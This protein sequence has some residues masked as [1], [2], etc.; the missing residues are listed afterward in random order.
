MTP[1]GK[2]VH[3]SNH[4]FDLFRR[5]G[6]FVVARYLAARARQHVRDGRPPVAAF[7]FD[8]IGRDIALNGQ[9]ER[10]DLAALDDFLCPFR[11]RFAQST[12]LDIGANIGNH[13]LFFARRFAAVHSFEPNPRTYGVLAVNAQ[14]APNITT[15]NV[16]LGDEP[17]LLT[18]TFNPLNVGEASLIAGQGAAGADHSDVKV[19]ILDDFLPRLDQITLMKIDVEGFEAPVLRGARQTIQTHR[20]IVVFEQNADAF[21]EGRSEVAEL[22]QREGYTLCV[23]SKRH[24]DTG[25]VGRLRGV[26]RKVIKGVQFD[27]TPVDTLIPGHYSMIVA[28]AESDMTLLAQ[29]TDAAV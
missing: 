22:L 12:A 2:P 25:M 17:G 27:I 28:L 9:F 13:S 18:L 7:A 10:E 26:I 1:A 29:R 5:L 8:Y 19:E 14:L 3:S 11:E 24:A 23:L 4:R 16:A 21:I 15:H 20:P 6:D